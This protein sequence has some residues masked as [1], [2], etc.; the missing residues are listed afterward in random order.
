[1]INNS[2][3]NDSNNNYDKVVIIM[4]MLSIV[5]MAPDCCYPGCDNRDKRNRTKL[6]MTRPAAAWLLGCRV[7]NGT[8]WG[9]H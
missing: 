8:K 3:D 2:D 7:R 1:M 5:A 4:I 6:C 9:Q